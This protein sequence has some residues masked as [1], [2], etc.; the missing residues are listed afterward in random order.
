MNRV[1]KTAILSMAVAAATLPA[2]SGANADEWRH[3]RHFRGGD[4]VAAGVLGLATGAI[5]AGIASQPSYRE[6]VYVDPPYRPHPQRNYVVDDYYAEPEVVYVDR[7]LE[8]WSRSWYRYC[9]QRY[10]SF[11][12]GTGTFVGYDGREHFCTAE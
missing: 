1:L 11:N 12:P 3:H 4:A 7:A 9:E 10:R 5:I 2:L 6:P 8:P